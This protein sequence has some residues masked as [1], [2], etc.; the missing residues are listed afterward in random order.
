MY[1]GAKR[2]HVVRVYDLSGISGKTVMDHPEAKAMLADV[3]AGR[4]E[5]LIF[6]K[7]ARLAR[8]TKELLEFSDFFQEHGADLVSLHESIDTSSPAGRLF[9]TL[10]AAMAQWEREEIAERVRASVPV[11]AK[12]GKSL[13]GAAPFGYQRV[14]GK[15]ELD[16]K[17]API[18]KLMFEMFLKERRLKTVANKLNEAG[19]RTRRGGKFRDAAIKRNL[20]DPIAKGKRRAN[21][22]Q[23]LGDK[24]H[25]VLKPES[26]WVYYDVPA[27]VDEA[28]FEEVNRIIGAN[29]PN[30]PVSRKAK[31]LFAG[32]TICACGKKMYRHTRSPKYICPTC[33]NKIPET[34][35]ELIF[36]EQLKGFFLNPDAISQEVEA[37]NTRLQDRKKLLS[38]TTQEIQMLK[39]EMDQIYQLYLA[40]GLDTQAFYERNQPLEERRRALRAELPR[41]QGEIDALAIDQLSLDQVVSDS[42]TLYDNWE[43][44]NFD[45]RRG[46]VETVVEEIQIGEGDIEIKLSYLPNPTPIKTQS[47]SKTSHSSP[48]KGGAMHKGHG[49]LRGSCLPPA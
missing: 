46:V 43:N 35:L 44:L 36:V 13:G 23:S 18:R 8:N 37:S 34:D 47:N 30:R 17:E 45:E 42:E 19:Y 1:A 48:Y 12:L 21:Y 22:T 16:E 27:I 31:Y 2:W 33:R 20:T 24:R 7:L 14:N 40:G 3:R 41:L 28:T 11:R 38:A 10:I 9:Y 39:T 29:K 25:W 32:R 26:E 4:I 5:A 49:N 6:S 15:L